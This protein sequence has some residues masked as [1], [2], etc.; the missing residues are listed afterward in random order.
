MSTSSADVRTGARSPTIWSRV[1]RCFEIGARAIEI[2]LTV[3][4]IFAV[5][6]NFATA[7]DRYLFKHSIIGADEVQTYIMVWMTF[8]GAAVVSWRHQHLRMDVIVARL[9][10]S[11][12]LALLGVEL[13][14]AL[15]LTAV[16]A[17][18]SYGYAAQMHMLDRRSDL[19]SLPMWIPHSALFVGFA[20]MALLTVWR[21]VE[22]F[23]ARVEPEKHPTEAAL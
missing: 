13:L 1:D 12:R 20:L 21:I 19:A 5:L 4:F 22:L 2:V 17:Y 3:A 18:E 15:V 7:A 9:P 10:R 16:L 11:V 14:L 6:L 23:A 8:A